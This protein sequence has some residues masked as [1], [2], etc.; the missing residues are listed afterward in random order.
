MQDLPHIYKV[1]ADADSN[2][3]V[4]VSSEGVPSLETAGPVEFGG[5]GDVWSPEE[6]F[7]AALADCFVLTF[8]AMA[9]ASKLEWTSISCKASGTL[10]KVDKVTQFTR[11]DMNAALTVP[12]GIDEGKAERLM[13]RAERHCLIT[14]SLKAGT[15]LDA[16]VTTAD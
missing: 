15:T 6:L 7:V 4:I 13:Q 3:A 14:N 1:S 12:P 8:R 5:P 10:D 9:R 11:F 16:T 2:S